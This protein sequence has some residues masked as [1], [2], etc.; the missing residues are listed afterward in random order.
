M[1]VVGHPRIAKGADEDGIVLTQ[2][3]VTIVWNRDA[4]LKKMLGAPWQDLELG[5]AAEDLARRAKHLQG[6]RRHLD[7]DAVTRDDCYA[8]GG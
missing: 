7:A 5:A 2:P 8:H 3:C 6:F 1:A 4:R